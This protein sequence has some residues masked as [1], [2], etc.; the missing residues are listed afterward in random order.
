M[1]Q[2]ESD[3]HWYVCHGDHDGSRQ[4]YDIFFSMC[5]KYK[6]SWASASE[7]ERYF[8]EAM[9]DHAFSLWLAQQEGTTTTPP[10]EVFSTRTAS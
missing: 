4:Y 8:I 3:A 1:Y 7:K 10:K 9:T 2:Y 5:H 6:I